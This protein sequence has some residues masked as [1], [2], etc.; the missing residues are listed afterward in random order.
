MSMLTMKSVLH[1]SSADWQGHAKVVQLLIEHGAVVDHT[2]NQGATA[3]CIAAQE[4]HID[5]V[6]V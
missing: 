6:Q 5:V 4:G 1:C 3:L 2:C